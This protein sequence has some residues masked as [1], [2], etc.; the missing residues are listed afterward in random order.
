MDDSEYVNTGKV[1]CH[2]GYC[3]GRTRDGKFSVGGEK[4]KQG[5]DGY[6]DDKARLFELNDTNKYF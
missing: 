4:Q 5:V 6:I 2:N 3:N 1:L